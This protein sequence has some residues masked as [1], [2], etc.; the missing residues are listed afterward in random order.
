MRESWI[1]YA[2]INNVDSRNRNIS[3]EKRQLTY[4]EKAINKLNN[5]LRSY[6]TI[7]PYAARRCY[8]N[9]ELEFERMYQ[10]VKQDIN[11][12]KAKVLNRI[13][14]EDDG[15]SSFKS[16]HDNN[17]ESK[18]DDNLWGSF[19]KNIKWWIGK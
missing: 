16:S 5:R 19:A 15:I 11:D 13:E 3:W 18:E 8:L 6:N 10:D 7:A 2:N 14:K 1:R 17:M 12:H 9:I 4:Y